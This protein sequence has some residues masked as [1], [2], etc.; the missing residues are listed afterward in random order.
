MS[1]IEHPS[2]GMVTVPAYALQALLQRAPGPCLDETYN[3]SWQALAAAAAGGLAPQATSVVLAAVPEPTF[4][5]FWSVYPRREGKIAARKAWD[6]AVKN[7]V[8]PS[9]IIDGAAR[10][11]DLAGR[12]GNFTAHPTT[13]LNRGSWDDELVPRTTGSK[14]DRTRANLVA[15]AQQME[16][17][18][19][20]EERMAA[21]GQ[22]EIEAGS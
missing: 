14:V 1:A 18:M 10:Y 9:V 13:W 4:D 11:R 2:A 15:G 22:H 7:G 5:D 16:V 3:R 20:F 6:K 8:R 21:A 17:G 12:E 19:T